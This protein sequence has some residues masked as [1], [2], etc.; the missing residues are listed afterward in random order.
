MN[1]VYMGKMEIYWLC[2]KMPENQTTE[3]KNLNMNTWK[4]NSGWRVIK[5]LFNMY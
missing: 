4:L 3:K 1:A 5:Q 2:I